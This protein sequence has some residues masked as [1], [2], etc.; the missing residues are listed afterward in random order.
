MYTAWTIAV[1]LSAFQEYN[2]NNSERIYY[3][4]IIIVPIKSQWTLVT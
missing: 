2:Q 1:R 3:F 4:P